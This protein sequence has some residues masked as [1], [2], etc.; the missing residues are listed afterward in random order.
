LILTKCVELLFGQFFFINSSGHPGRRRRWISKKNLGSFAKLSPQKTGDRCYDFWNIFAEKSGEN[1]GVFSQITASS[2][3]NL[4]LTLVF[5]KTPFLSEIWQKSLKIVI[6]TSIQGAMSFIV[7][8]GT[9]KKTTK[10]V[11]EKNLRKKS[12]HEIFFFDLNVISSES[13][14]LFK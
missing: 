13:Y 9:W 3:K 1:I 2:S 4:I 11:S 14:F 10:L 7:V 12:W 5:E 8:N 6:V